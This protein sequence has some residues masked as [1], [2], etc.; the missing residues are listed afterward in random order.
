MGC[1]CLEKSKSNYYYQVLSK[2]GNLNE[3][4]G[5]LEVMTEDPFLDA[6]ETM[7]L[8]SLISTA[9]GSVDSCS[10]EEYVNGDLLQFCADIGDQWEAN[11][12]EEPGVEFQLTTEEENIYF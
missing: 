3:N 8:G 10:V 4:A 12:M 2:A 6:D 11:F 7:S 5:V 1:T 9:M